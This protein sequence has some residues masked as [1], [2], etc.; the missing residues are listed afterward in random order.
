MVYSLYSAGKKLDSAF[1][2][3]Y[4]HFRRK[5]W[6]NL[7]SADIILTVYSLYRARKER[8]SVVFKYIN[9]SD[10]DIDKIFKMLRNI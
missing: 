5:Y 2:Q 9:I 6:E 4:K 1:F 10:M 3:M 8:D 7:L